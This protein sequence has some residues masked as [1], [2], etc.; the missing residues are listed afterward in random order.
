[1]LFQEAIAAARSELGDTYVGN[2][3]YSPADMLRYAVDGVR[4][5]WRVRPSLKYNTATGALYDPATVLPPTVNE[6]HY[7]VPLPEEVQYAITYYIVFR[8]LSRDVTDAG[9]ANA[10]TIAKA[11]FDQIIAG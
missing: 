3:S 7:E 9:N 2:Y 11:R 6:D 5:A 1:M 10:A 4:E 8:C